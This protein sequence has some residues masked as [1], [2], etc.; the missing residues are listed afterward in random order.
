MQENKLTP[1]EIAAKSEVLA[2]YM[3]KTI[4][5]ILETGSNPLKGYFKP[6]EFEYAIKAGYKLQFNYHTSW[7]RLHE[8]WENVQKDK[9]YQRIPTSQKIDL[10]NSIVYDTPEQCFIA[11]VECVEFLNNL[12]Q[13]KNAN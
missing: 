8:V 11:L 3:E 12:K 1:T 2:K 7:D 10:T 4:Y 13:E 9:S 6:N 5:G